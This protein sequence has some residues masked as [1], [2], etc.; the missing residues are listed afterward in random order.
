MVLGNHPG[1]RRSPPF[2]RLF[3][4]V[5]SSALFLCIEIEMCTAVAQSIKFKIC[6]QHSNEYGEPKWATLRCDSELIAHLKRMELHAKV[7]L[8]TQNNAFSVCFV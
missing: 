7:T 3:R 1:N 8:L 4:A 5:C 2:R 6:R